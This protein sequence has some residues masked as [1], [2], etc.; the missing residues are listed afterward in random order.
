MGEPKSVT[1]SGISAGRVKI[2]YRENEWQRHFKVNQ[3]ID[4]FHF[5]EHFGTEIISADF[6]HDG[7]EGIFVQN[8]KGHL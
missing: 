8:L 7:L 3:I 4:G 2:I 5:N 6:N 1:L